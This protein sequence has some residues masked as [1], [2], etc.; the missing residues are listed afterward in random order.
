ME[1]EE[2]DVGKLVTAIDRLNSSIDK[3]DKGGNNSH[4]SINANGMYISVTCVI[5]LLVLS[6]YQSRDVAE[7]HR[8]YDR[9]QDYLN[10]IYM[11][12]PQLR[13]KEKE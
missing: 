12:A 9:M 7:M 5:I 8:K 13:P 10:A 3:I 4:A 2:G 11:Q 1:I 6:L